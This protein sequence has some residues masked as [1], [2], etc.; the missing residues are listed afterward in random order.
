MLSHKTSV[1]MSLGDTLLP[2]ILKAA[3]EENDH[4]KD[5][6]DDVHG[7]AATTRATATTTTTR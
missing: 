3:V 7:G 2:E 1:E 4:D 6:H 5:N